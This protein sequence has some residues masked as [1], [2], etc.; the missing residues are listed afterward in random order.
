MRD[1]E[2]LCGETS[3][4]FLIGPNQNAITWRIF[5]IIFSCPNTRIGCIQGIT[6]IDAAFCMSTTE[7][8]R[9]VDKC[10]RVRVRCV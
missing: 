3:L 8:A 4:Q 9:V 6:D 7:V 10:V 2:F 5:G 1:L